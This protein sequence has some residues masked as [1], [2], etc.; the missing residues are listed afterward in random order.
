MS[1][2]GWLSYAYSLLRTRLPLPLRFWAWTPA[3]YR[4]Q[5]NKMAEGSRNTRLPSGYD[6]DFVDAFEED[7]QCSVRQ[8]TLKEPVLER[9]GHRLCK[10]CQPRLF[11]GQCDSLMIFFYT[12]KWRDALWEWDLNRISNVYS[13]THHYKWRAIS[14]KI[15]LSHVVKHFFYTAARF[16]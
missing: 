8:L 7:F 6:E 1:W 16:N 11:L 4:V 13:V 2:K 10:E 5:V 9:Y 15:L 12:P 14:L 3:S